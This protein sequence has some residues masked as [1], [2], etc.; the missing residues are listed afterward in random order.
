MAVIAR[1]VWRARQIRALPPDEVF[2]GRGAAMQEIRLGMQRAEPTYLPILIQGETGTGKELLATLLHTRGPNRSGPLFCV[3]CPTASGRWLQNEG[4]EVDL[5]PHCESEIGKPEAEEH[6][7][8]GTIFFDEIGELADGLQSQ[9]DTRLERALTFALSTRRGKTWELRVISATVHDLAEK[10][11]SGSFLRS[12]SNRVQRFT[13]R[14]PPLRERREDIPY[15]AAY[16]LEVYQ[17]KFQRSVP[18]LSEAWVHHLARREWLGNIRE[19]ENMMCS[20]VVIGPKATLR[21]E[22]ESRHGKGLSQE[23]LIERPGILGRIA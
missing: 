2:F 9:L 1:E 14:L 17:R 12:L 19:L 4:I 18:S 6:T 8:N 3:R 21:A 20:Y 23:F 13:L 11:K 10:V 22:A 15:L 5:R 16:F 7:A